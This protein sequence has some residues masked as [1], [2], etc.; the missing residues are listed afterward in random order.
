MC[1]ALG[2]LLQSSLREIVVIGS[3]EVETVLK[4]FLA[5]VE[6]GDK[7]ITFVREDPNNLSLAPDHGAWAKASSKFSP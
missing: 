4:R 6:T 5:V 2:N 1:Y 7:K 3:P